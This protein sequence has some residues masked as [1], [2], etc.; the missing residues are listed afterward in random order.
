MTYDHDG[1]EPCDCCGQLTDC[2]ILRKW[3]KCELCRFLL[4]S[5]KIEGIF[6]RPTKDQIFKA[7]A[8]IALPAVGV[9]D[10]C[11]MC[12]AFQPGALLRTQ[13]G[14]DV[15]IGR[16]KP[17]KGGPEI[18]LDLQYILES[19]AP[20]HVAHKWFE[21]LRPFMD[22]NGRTGRIY[23]YWHMLKLGHKTHLSFLETWY[24]QSL[25]EDVLE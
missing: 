6:A 21:A 7:R 8:F 16:H 14:M 9:A 13:P 4:D 18:I 24:R 15:R 12:N 10:L 3:G 1:Q 25:E 22:G 20:P 19:E 23:W 11:N 17:P 5:N 2:F